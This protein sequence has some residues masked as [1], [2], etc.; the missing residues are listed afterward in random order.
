MTGNHFSTIITS[1][2][3]KDGLHLIEL[4][5]NLICPQ[6]LEPKQSNSTT[7][8]KYTAAITLLAFS[9]PLAKADPFHRVVK[10]REISPQVRQLKDSKKTKEEKGSSSTESNSDDA[11]K[12]SKTKGD[13]ASSK[14]DKKKSKKTKAK[15]RQWLVDDLLAFE[16]KLIAPSLI[17][18]RE[19][20]TLSVPRLHQWAIG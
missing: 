5:N 7:T 1:K 3:G 4:T 8:M 6:K 16:R 19:K 18:H 17:P 15:V 11:K 10:P 13:K 20:S 12:D 2:S 9:L 14:D